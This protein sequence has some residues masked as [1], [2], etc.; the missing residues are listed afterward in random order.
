MKNLR[1]LPM[2][3]IAA[4]IISGCSATPKNA[5]LTEA[6]DS[7]NNARTN[8]DISNQASLELKEASDT[9]NKADEAFKDDE[10]EQAV[11]HLA[12]IATQQVAIAR[13]TAKRK[14]SEIASANATAKRDEVRLAARTAE[15]DAAERQL[16]AAGA[17]TARDQALI[18]QQEQ[19]LKELN[20]E[21]TERG[22]LITLGDVLFRTNRAQ[23]E[24]GGLR[25]VEKLADFLN[26][27]QSYKVLIEGHT[28]S[29]GSHNYNQE[30]SDRRAYS[31]RMALVDRNVG[32]DRI[33][34]RGYAEEYPVADNDTAANRQL[35]RR[36]EIVVSDI[37]GRI[38]QR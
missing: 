24:P 17:N 25:N 21:K 37:T 20:A 31:V 34:T 3:L 19:Q 28:D 11:N 9:L 36:V 14:I 8:A 6:H 7:F 33:K 35:N 13:E 38:A 15:A 29:T 18:A 5:N 16:A 10:D 2:T 23:L 30:L 22:Y 1:Y 26:Q 12:Y 27:Y 4:A 32:S